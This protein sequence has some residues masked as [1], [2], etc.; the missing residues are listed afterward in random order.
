MTKDVEHLFK[1]MSAIWDS[2]LRIHFLFLYPIFIGL[3]GSLES[4]F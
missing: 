1:S 4:N 3:I 2:Q